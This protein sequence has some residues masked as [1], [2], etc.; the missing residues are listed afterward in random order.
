MDWSKVIIFIAASCSLPQT[1]CVPHYNHHHYQPST[2]PAH[3][4][5][6]S[7]T[8]TNNNNPSVTI[9]HNNKWGTVMGTHQY[10]HTITS[11]HGSSYQSVNFTYKM[12]KPAKPHLPWTES[13]PHPTQ[14]PSTTTTTY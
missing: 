13:K 12:N 11:S 5:N 7:V 1:E 6:P 9:T 8:I 4:N 10:G 2:N 14:K 3:N